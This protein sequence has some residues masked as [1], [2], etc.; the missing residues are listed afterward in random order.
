MFAEMTCEVTSPS[1][2]VKIYGDVDG[3]TVVI[4][5]MFVAW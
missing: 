2:P 5:P 1:S 4:M 3:L